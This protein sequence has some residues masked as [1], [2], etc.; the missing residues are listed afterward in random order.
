M[1]VQ[2]SAPAAKDHAVEKWRSTHSGPW[3]VAALG[4]LHSGDVAAHDLLD[5]AAQVPPGSSPYVTVAYHRVRLARESGD[6]VTARR[7]LKEALAQGDTL[8]P[9]TADLL[10][11]QQMMAAADLEDFLSH[12]WQV[13]ILFDSDSGENDLC[14]DPDCSLPLYG[15]TKP[16]QN[17]Q[18]LPQFSPAAATALIRKFL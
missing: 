9:S 5:A 11:D 1:T 6:Y 18:P 14:S 12:L 17:A 2:S 10:Q 15:T 7:I 4:K 8:P 3:L 13:P 16:S